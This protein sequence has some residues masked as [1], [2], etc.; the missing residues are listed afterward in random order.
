ML[1]EEQV[2]DIL[3]KLGKG[4]IK[5]HEI[6]N[7]T[8]NDSNEAARIRRLFLEKKYGLELKNIASVV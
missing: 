4:E 7:F 3:E 8:M 2:K 6:E 1:G 5:I